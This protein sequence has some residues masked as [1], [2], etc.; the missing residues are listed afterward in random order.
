[1]TSQEQ[2]QYENA[3]KRVKKVKGF[4]THLIVYVVINIMIIIVNIQNLDKEDSYFQIENFFTAFFWG[5]GLLSHALS[6]FGPNL[7]LGKDWEDKKIK[8]LMEKENSNQQ[9]W[10]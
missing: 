9:K 6:V 3:L 4:Y 7:F 5:I 2:I 8:E 10:Q 1:M